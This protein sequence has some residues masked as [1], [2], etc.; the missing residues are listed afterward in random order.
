ME[1]EADTEVVMDVVMEAAMDEDM[2][3]VTDVVM[4]VE[5]ITVKKCNKYKNYF[6]SMTLPPIHE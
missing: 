5:D 2:A 4:A 3:V 1:A 6:M